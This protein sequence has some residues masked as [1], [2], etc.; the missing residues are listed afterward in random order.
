[1]WWQRFEVSFSLL[2]KTKSLK[3]LS[4][5]ALNFKSLCIYRQGKSEIWARLYDSRTWKIFW[6]FYPGLCFLSLWCLWTLPHIW[7]Y[8]R[9]SCSPLGLFLALFTT[10]KKS[11]CLT[12]KLQLRQNNSCLFGLKS[13]LVSLILSAWWEYPPSGNLYF[14]VSFSP[15]VEIYDSQGAPEFS[16]YLKS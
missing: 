12:L 2:P 16:L 8:F 9:W 10:E 4:F 5:G 6:K 7:F 13:A 11:S 3:T 14:G 15:R 1:M